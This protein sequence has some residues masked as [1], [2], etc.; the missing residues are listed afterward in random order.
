MKKRLAY[1]ILLVCMAIVLTSGIAARCR[2]YTVRPICAAVVGQTCPT[3][4]VKI[5]LPVRR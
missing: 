5:C 1:I 4:R 3:F 2:T